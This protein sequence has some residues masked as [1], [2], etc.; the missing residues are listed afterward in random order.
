MLDWQQI[1][2]WKVL[3]VDDEP[4]N[5]S[6]V[7]DVLEFYGMSVKTARDG[8]TGLGILQSYMPTLILLDLS[9]PKM[10]GW[11]MLKRVKAEQ[12][13]QTVPV[14]A[15]TAHAMPGD[16]K[17]VFE[18]G[19]DGY[20]TKPIA[21]PTLI[22]DLRT[23]LETTAAAS[24]PV[25]SS[26]EPPAAV[27]PVASSDEPPAAVEPVASSDELPVAAVEPAVSSD[28]LPAS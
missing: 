4:D 2:T 28:E 23:A 14:V 19:F 13:L 21:V 7:A 16:R 10:D 18:A 20:L 24:A 25:A 6:V 5:L 9:M 15:L 11:E 17:R 3:I 22:E 26:D 1:K 8:E 27:E 12:A